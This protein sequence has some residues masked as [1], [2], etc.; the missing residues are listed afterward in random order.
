[1]VFANKSLG[2]CLSDCT[3]FMKVMTKHH[4]LHLLVLPESQAAPQAFSPRVS[5]IPPARHRFCSSE[6]VIAN[7]WEFLSSSRE[8]CVWT[9]HF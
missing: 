3:F 4:V 8:H 2:F 1:M 9:R 7:V 5:L 6:A